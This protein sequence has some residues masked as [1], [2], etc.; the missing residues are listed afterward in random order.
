MM[1][2]RDDLRVCIANRALC[3]LCGM[4]PGDIVGVPITEVAGGKCDS[5]ELRAGLRSVLSGAQPSMSLQLSVDDRHSGARA[6][7]MRAK[8][9]ALDGAPT[10]L[11]EITDITAQARKQKLHQDILANVGD[12]VIETDLQFRIWGWNRGAETMYGWSAQEAIGRGIADVIPTEFEGNTT[13]SVRQQLFADGQWSGDAIQKRRGGE[14]VS[15]DASITLLR[16][17]QG[18][19]L[20]VVAINRDIT[21]RKCATRLLARRARQQEAV[22]KLGMHAVNLDAQS[23][24][25]Q[26]VATVA[27]ILKVDRC[28][29]FELMPGGGDMLLREGF[30][31][32]AE[33][34]R[35]ATIA[36]ADKSLASLALRSNQPFV[37]SDARTDA[38]LAGSPAQNDDQ[39]TCGLSVVIPGRDEPFGVLSVK[40]GER[41]AFSPDDVHFLQAVANI[42]A[43][44]MT[45]AEI[46]TQLRHANRLNTVSHL[47]VSLTHEFGTPLNVISAYAKMMLRGQLQGDEQVAGLRAISEQVGRATHLVRQLLDFSRQSP[48]GKQADAV[49]LLVLRTVDMLR[50]LARQRRVSLDLAIPDPDH[51]AGM[52]EQ[53]LQQVLSNLIINA[54]DAQ[55]GG[56]RVDIDISI[57]ARKPSPEVDS[58]QEYICISIADQGP[59]VPEHLEEQIF[60]AFFTT[61]QAGR[62]TGLGLSV[63]RQLIEDAGG[64]LELRANRPKGARFQVYVPARFER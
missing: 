62:G 29:V 15:V 51:A 45:R 26:A 12:A 44:V 19:P 4:P 7:E 59:G 27:D 3:A 24:L 64:M 52:A 20:G 30:G 13:R 28:E 63:S 23:V 2:V 31:C 36:V 16:D 47:A 22:A 54:I 18:N 41:R 34:I 60:A 9:L 40:S 53:A 5:V 6:F 56:G 32:P 43:E 57:E 38:R 33:L 58:E 1:V 55:T 42:I 10:L 17:H 61:K 25:E 48:T 35:S 8:P 11:V 14:L 37:V 21:E 46:T 49:G 50:P 39:A